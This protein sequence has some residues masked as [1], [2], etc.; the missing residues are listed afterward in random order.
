MSSCH[1]LCHNPPAILVPRAEPQGPCES[2]AAVFARL[3]IVT[4]FLDDPGDSSGGH[5]PGRGV[6]PEVTQGPEI[7][8]IDTI[9][10]C[11]SRVTHEWVMTQGRPQG[12]LGS[13]YE[14]RMN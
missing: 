1:A 6:Y 10:P 9:G 7:V 13:T 4:R 12:M 11:E 8:K 2:R 3:A 14:P 5:H